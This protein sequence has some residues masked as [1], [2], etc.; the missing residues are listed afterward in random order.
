M[1]GLVWTTWSTVL[2][3][4]KRTTSEIT[5]WRLNSLVLSAGA[6]AAPRTCLVSLALFTHRWT[7]VTRI[8]EE[9]KYERGS[10]LSQ[11]KEEN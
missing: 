5:L 11:Q 9:T 2:N 10:Y 4:N 3:Q 7:R 6:G 8:L 1:H